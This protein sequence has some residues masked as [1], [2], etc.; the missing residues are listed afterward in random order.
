MEEARGRL[1][2]PDPA[3]HIVLLSKERV[4]CSLKCQET[5]ETC[6]IFH[7]KKLRLRD[8]KQL[9]Q[10]CVTEVCGG[11]ERPAPVPPIRASYPFILQHKNLPELGMKHPVASLGCLARQSLSKT[12]MCMEGSWLARGLVMQPPLPPE[13]TVE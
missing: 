6:F 10:G 12:R 1:S 13:E 11:T 2:P 9:A 3:H 4:L 5:T 7:V 8:L